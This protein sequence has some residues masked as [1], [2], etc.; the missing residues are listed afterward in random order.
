MR[1]T[2]THIVA[3]DGSKLTVTTRMHG[4][5]ELVVRVYRGR[6]RL[7]AGEPVMRGEFTAETPVKA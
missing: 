6:D 2:V 4:E 7:V 5:T 1:P 3:A